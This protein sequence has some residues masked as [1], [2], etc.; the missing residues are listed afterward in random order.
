M[1]KQLIDKIKAN[2]GALHNL[3]TLK[4]IDTNIDNEEYLDT[5]QNILDSLHGN[6]DEFKKL[7]GV[8]YKYSEHV[9]DTPFYFEV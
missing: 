6:L 3:E 4:K 8:E 5:K 2:Y 9:L 7:T 1:E